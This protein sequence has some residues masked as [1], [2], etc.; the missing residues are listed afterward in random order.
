MCEADKAYIR[1]V[2]YKSCRGWGLRAGNMHSSTCQTRMPT[3]LHAASKTS[4]KHCGGGN[5]T[6]MLSIYGVFWQQIMVSLNAS[7]EENVNGAGMPNLTA[8]MVSHA[9]NTYTKELGAQV[10]VA[11]QHS[12]AWLVHKPQLC[13]CRNALRICDGA[14]HTRPW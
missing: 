3:S 13:H 8:S 7:H 2:S 9:A 11:L 10:N 1:F 14:W 4:C 5:F 6:H 12:I